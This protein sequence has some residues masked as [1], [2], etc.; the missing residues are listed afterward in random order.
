MTRTRYALE[1]NPRLPPELARLDELANDLWYS[2]DRPTR[3]L[4]AHMDPKLWRITGHNPKAFLKR[5]DQHKLDKA[6]RDPEFLGSFAQV[7][8]AY[9]VYHT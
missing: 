3:A 5:V 1:I 8:S 6:A 4:F 9:D 2:W 7:L